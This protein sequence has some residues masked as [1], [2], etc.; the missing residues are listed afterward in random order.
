[1]LV[2]LAKDQNIP[3][4]VIVF[5]DELPEGDVPTQ[6]AIYRL[7]NERMINNSPIHP[8]VKMVAAGNRAIDGA[9]TEKLL[10]TVA[11]RMFHITI[12]VDHKGWIKWATGKGI[13]PIIRA[14]IATTP[15]K[16]HRYDEASDEDAWASPRTY[17]RLNTFLG[18]KPLT[19]KTPVV[20]GAP[21][22][23]LGSECG[24][25]L[26]NFAAAT[27]LPPI[28]DVLANPTGFAINSLSP[29]SLFLLGQSL[30][31]IAD[32][33]NIT[34]ILKVMERMPKDHLAINY[35]GLSGLPPATMSALMASP[36]FVAFAQNHLDMLQII[37]KVK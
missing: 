18:T 23:F 2:P 15:D 13:S 14:F 3:S 7:L 10:P 19:D 20:Q 35:M 12:K 27:D 1:M 26:L 25:A 30:I 24:Q 34:Q 17:E 31:S 33:S 8:N 9:H 6:K 37:A 4:E 22:M 36:D 29:G 28:A 11:N 5:I 16:L 32:P 21:V